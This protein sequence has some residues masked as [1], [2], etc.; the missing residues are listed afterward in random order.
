MSNELSNVAVAG[1]RVASDR[2]SPALPLLV[3]AAVVAGAMAM[4][5]LWPQ[6][7][8]RVAD[9]AG[10]STPATVDNSDFALT[11]PAAFGFTYLPGLVYWVVASTIGYFV[12]A[13]IA[14]RQ[15]Y[16]SGIW[17]NRRPL[18][19]S[20]LF[21]L[22][23]MITVTVGRWVPE[24][25]LL[26][27]YLP[28]IA[29]TVAVIVWGRYEHRPALWGL[30]IITTVLAVTANLYNMENVFFRLGLPDFSTSIDTVNLAVVAAVLLVG[31]VGFALH[32]SR[33]RHVGGSR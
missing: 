20:G 25:L 29:M 10:G 17:A 13:M 8:I 28:V 9:V 15:G 27:G 7:V 1:R 24:S 3:M 21:G 16:T 18:L 26:R 11:S 4:A 5:L 30:G 32:K 2:P 33:T 6:D 22:M 23:A 12:I 31:S 14:R 19:F